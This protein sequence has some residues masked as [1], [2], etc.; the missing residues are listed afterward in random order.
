MILQKVF[1]NLRSQIDE[2]GGHS[3]QYIG[4]CKSYRVMAEAELD[5]H[6]R[7]VKTGLFCEA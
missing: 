4:C 1:S 7:I 3:T 5:S 6:R 2:T